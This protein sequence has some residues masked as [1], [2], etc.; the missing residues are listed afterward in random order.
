MLSPRERFLAKVRHIPGAAPVVSPFLPKPELLEATLRYL[1]LP[2][3]SDPVE[4]EIRVAR[5]LRYEPMLIF[6]QGVPAQSEEDIHQLTATCQ[7]VEERD[8]E[9]HRYFREWREKVGDEGV[10]V[11]GHPLVPWL[12]L[13]VSQQ[14]MVFFESDYP[15]AYHA[16]T[17]AILHAALHVFAIA[18]QEGIDFLSE[19]G[20]GLEMVSPGWYEKYDLS[21]IPRLTDWT[22]AHGG[23]FWYH[24][25]GRT[26]ELIRR[27]YFNRLGADVI[28]TISPP[29]EGNN[30]LAAARTL[31]DPRICTKGNLSL[32]LLRDG[33]PEVVEEATRRMVRAVQGYS[34]IY[35]T[36]DAVF[37]ETPVENFVTFL[38]T[39]R[40]EAE[41]LL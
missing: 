12:S 19:G 6:P 41:K 31:L 18:M 13:Q 32:I 14:D 1:H 5:T 3:S 39:A 8:P 7:R 38:R 36:A 37:A 4:N 28:E 24:N 22:H 15:E 40:E 10:I 27:G 26:R 29:P 30:D 33:T 34:H 21:Y 23:L 35:S 11:I 25:C 2:T 9:I 20:Y 16:C 17:E